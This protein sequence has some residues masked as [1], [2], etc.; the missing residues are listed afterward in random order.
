METAFTSEQ[1]E[2]IGQEGEVRIETRSAAGAVHRTIIWIVVEGGEVFVRSVKGPRGRWYR[3]LL[4]ART[5]AILIGRDRIEVSAERTP[6]EE[7]VERTTRALQ[8]KYAADPALRSMVRQDTLE[9][10]VRLRP[11]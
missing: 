2:R 4:A 11:A 6:D 9:T 8:Q 3:E 10:T 1:L 7:S 5:G